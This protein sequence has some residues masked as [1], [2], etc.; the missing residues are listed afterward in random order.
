[1]SIKGGIMKVKY[2]IPVSRLETNQVRNYLILYGFNEKYV[3]EMSPMERRVELIRELE[4][5]G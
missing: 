2:V 1:M 4:D 5:R 3:D